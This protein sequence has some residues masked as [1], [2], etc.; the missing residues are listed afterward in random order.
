MATNRVFREEEEEDCPCVTHDDVMEAAKAIRDGYRREMDTRLGEVKAQLALDLGKALEASLA[1]SLVAFQ[2]AGERRIKALHGEY[3]A[4]VKGLVDQHQ[5][6]LGELNR[7]HG[8]S[9][10]RLTQ[11]V[12]ALHDVPPPSVSVTVPESAIEVKMLP[13][14]V[15]VPAEAI[16]VKMLPSQVVLPQSAIEVKM[17]PS[18]VVLPQDAIRVEVGQPNIQVSVPQPRLVKKSISYDEYGRPAEI[19]EHDAEV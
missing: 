15:H 7:M 5:K 17:L 14:E 16:T 8:E 1:K 12:K 9:L 3:E 18:Q 11:C 13:S 4:T 19:Q 6:Q 2:E 10:E